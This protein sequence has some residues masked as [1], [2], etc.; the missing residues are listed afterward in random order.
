MGNETVITAPTMAEALAKVR[1]ELGC[2]ALIMNHK[3]SHGNVSITACNGTNKSEKK[4]QKS[5]SEIVQDQQSK[6]P[7]WIRPLSPPSKI[8]TITST[9]EMPS[10]PYPK[11]AIPRSASVTNEQENTQISIPTRRSDFKELIKS[12]SFDETLI[13][14]ST[15]CDLCEF[16]QLGDALGEAW[17]KAMTPEFTHTPIQLEPALDCV[18]S[19][20]P[21]WLDGLTSTGQVVLVGPPGSGKTVTI[22]KLAAMLLDRGKKVRI[23]TLDTLKTSGAWQLEEYIK[24][25][26]LSLYVGFDY[27]PD[28]RPKEIIL[29]DTPGLNI[30][31]PRDRAYLK[32]LKAK[33]NVPYTLVLPA[34][35]NPIEAE[36][37]AQ[38]YIDANAK[39]V[40]ITR[41]ELSKRCGVPLRAAY[42]GLKLVLTSKS[43][44]L[45]E[46]LQCATPKILLE[47]MLAACEAAL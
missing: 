25:L 1:R 16:H 22:A 47:K 17:L 36:E 12:S 37:L 45:E 15:V 19:T 31:L 18:I 27:L 14:I 26:S 46:G 28:S 9:H 39:T 42:Q 4:A 24:P 29:I 34:D 8:D 20:D 10:T 40:I 11:T 30:N 3:E 38:A 35:M 21:N 7:N 6:I 43:P 44:E 13:A 2:D 23:I 5:K 32:A 41:L 33:V